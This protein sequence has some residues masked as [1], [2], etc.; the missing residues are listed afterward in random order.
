MEK[1]KS[2]L[3]KALGIG[4]LG[5]IGIIIVLT[6]IGSEVEQQNKSANASNPADVDLAAGEG[7]TEPLKVSAVQLARAYDSNEARAQQAYGDQQLLVTGTVAGVDLDL[8]D[9]PVVQLA[10]DNEFMPASA[11]LVNEDKPRA[12]DLDKGQKVV[13]LC[14]SVSEVMSMPQL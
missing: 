12:S 5:L 14:Q 7:A 8:T 10:T 2:R 3:G 4:C 11:Y 9:D 13:L 1:P 6:A